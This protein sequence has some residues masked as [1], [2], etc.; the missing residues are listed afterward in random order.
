[1]N[2][3]HW[4][5]MKYKELIELAEN[6]RNIEQRRNYYHQ[7]EKVLM[8]E[9]PIAPLFCLVHKYAKKDGIEGICFSKCGRIDLKWVVKQNP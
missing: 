9:M 6:E 1:M 5:N 4:E 3:S 2:V 7:A 8:E